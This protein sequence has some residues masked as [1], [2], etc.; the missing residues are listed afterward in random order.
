MPSQGEN[1][2]PSLSAVTGSVGIRGTGQGTDQRPSLETERATIWTPGRPPVREFSCPSRKHWQLT[3]TGFGGIRS[4]AEGDLPGT[5]V[6][7]SDQA[8]QGALHASL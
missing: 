4:V 6:D 2:G 3:D 7:A 5:L 8:T 1:R